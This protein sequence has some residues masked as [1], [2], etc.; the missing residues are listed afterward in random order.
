MSSAESLV[1]FCTPHLAV[2]TTNGLP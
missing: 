1:E 2:Q